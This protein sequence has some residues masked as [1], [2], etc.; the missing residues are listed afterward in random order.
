VTACFRQ[1]R[2]EGGVSVVMAERGEPILDLRRSFASAIWTLACGLALRS[3]PY[4][5]ALEPLGSG[6]QNR[7]TQ[8]YLVMLNTFLI[9]RL[10]VRI[11]S[12]S[13]TITTNLSSLAFLL[14][15]KSNK[16]IT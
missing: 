4:K 16:S 14:F 13:F 1:V 9:L 3:R 12:M 5:T 15:Q 7:T 6:G 11:T 10:V 2:K 8:T